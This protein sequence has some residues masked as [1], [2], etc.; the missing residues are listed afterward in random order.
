MKSD[1]IPNEVWWAHS[2]L[3]IGQ[4]V[5][6][7]VY[8]EL[9]RITKQYPEHFPWETTYNSIPKEVHDAYKLEAFGK[10]ADYRK[11]PLFDNEVP[12]GKGI[13]HEISEMEKGAIK[14]PYNGECTQQDLIDFFDRLAE[15][16]KREQE[17]K[18]RMIK[19]WNKH[20]SKY[21]LP[22]KGIY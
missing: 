19:I 21:K 15:N 14:M 5:G 22:Y 18:A 16:E 10:V 8:S 4:P 2:I 7:F 11:M 12:L 6:S 13:E 9:E 1:E 17:E 3:H 20:Y